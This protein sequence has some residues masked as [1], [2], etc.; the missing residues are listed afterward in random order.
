V[1]HF[2]TT[3][4]LSLSEMGEYITDVCV[5]GFHVYQA[6]WRPVI[7]EELPCVREESNN[8]DRYAV[9]IM[10]PGVGIVGHVPR[11]MSRLCSIFI[12]HGKEIYSVVTGTCQHSWDLPQGG[13]H[14]PCKYRFVGNGEELKMCPVIHEE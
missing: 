6:V 11:Y 7:G 3:R 12:S 1:V 14:I 10:K 9:A 13:M 5:R 8:K 2:F 4:D